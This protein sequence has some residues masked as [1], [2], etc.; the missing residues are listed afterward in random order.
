MA[1]CEAFASFHIPMNRVLSVGF[2]EST[3]WLSPK[4]RVCVALSHLHKPENS[5]FHLR[6]S[7]LSHAAMHQDSTPVYTDGSKSAGG[8]GAAAVFPDCALSHSLPVAASVFTAEL[9]AMIL[10]LSRI[11][12]L[13]TNSSYV[14]YSDSRS[15]L[16]AIGDIFSRHPLVLTIQRFLRL[17]HSRKRSVGFC[18]VP[19]HVDITGN[20]K[21]DV[22]AKRAASVPCSASAYLPPSLQ[23]GHLP[24]GDYL[25]VLRRGFSERWQ[26]L[27]SA[28]GPNKLLDLKPT[29]GLWRSS[30]S[31]SRLHEVSLT[32]LRIGH[33]HLTHGHL[34][35]RDPPPRCSF[36]HRPENITVHHLL[37]DCPFFGI[38]RNQCFPHLRSTPLTDNFHMF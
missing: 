34:M 26:L 30:C 15:A 16:D 20:E 1:F 6:T 5:A 28:S 24:A 2:G 21:A 25:P 19:S 8:V 36:C 10:A 9:W 11:L 32:R 12:R 14:L 22:E 3:P 7:F 31:R 33:S 4:P 23:L 37:L 13:N 38:L 27:W 35:T 18:W 29:L 17:L